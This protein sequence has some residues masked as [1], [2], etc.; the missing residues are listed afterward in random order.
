MTVP[1]PGY[2][3]DAVDRAVTTYITVASLPGPESAAAFGWA[4]A[5]LIEALNVNLGSAAA[6]LRAELDRRKL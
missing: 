2:V 5:G 4:C 6:L 1:G 3:T